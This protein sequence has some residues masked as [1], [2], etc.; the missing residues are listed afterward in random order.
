MRLRQQGWISVR[1]LRLTV[2]FSGL[3][4]AI[5][6]ALATSLH[7]LEKSEAYKRLDAV[8]EIAASTTSM[9]AEHEPTKT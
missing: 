9:S 8:L 7:L 1:L 6:I 5:V 2:G 4:G 3:F